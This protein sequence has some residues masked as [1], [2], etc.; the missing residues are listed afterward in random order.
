MQL[1]IYRT[2]FGLPAAIVLLATGVL[3]MAARLAPE[4]PPL[5]GQGIGA[6]GDEVD[7]GAQRR[8]TPLRARHGLA[9]PFFSF[10]A[11]S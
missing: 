7:V 1:R 4:L 10:G 6:T 8:A 5:A 2:R 11:R 3:L 9:V